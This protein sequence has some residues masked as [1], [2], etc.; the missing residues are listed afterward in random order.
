MHRQRSNHKRKQARQRDQAPRNR[1]Q[2]SVF[3]RATAVAAT[4][5]NTPSVIDPA[6]FFTT[7]GWVRQNNDPGDGS[8]SGNNSYKS[9]RPS[10][11]A[12]RRRARVKPLRACPYLDKNRRSLCRWINVSNHDPAHT[13]VSATPLDS[14]VELASRLVAT[15]SCAGIDPPQPVL[16]LARSW[17]A[18]NG[19]GAAPAQR[20]VGRAGRRACRDRRRRARPRALPRC[21][22]RYRA[23]RRPGPMERAALLRCGARRPAARPR[24]RHSKA[25]VA[26]LAHVARHF[27]ESGLPRGTLHVLF[28]ADE[29]TGRFGGVRAYLDAIARPPTRP[30]WAIPAMMPSSPAVAVSCAPGCAFPAWPRIPAMPSAAASMRY[31]GRRLRAQVGRTGFSRR[32]RRRLSLRTGRHG[33][34]HRGGEVSASCPTSRSA[35]STSA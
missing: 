11:G 18:E 9:G 17:L 12:R 21:L 6:L 16:S 35:M 24:R 19:L 32:A 30:R 33:D 22:H 20:S 5:S 1:R 31:Q 26:I 10:I 13:A 3:W 29:H 28:D 27:A 14:I 25:G 8:T 34:A 7:Q 2:R 23:G 4:S 15:P